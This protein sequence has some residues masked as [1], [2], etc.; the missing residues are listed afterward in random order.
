MTGKL[1][2]LVA[3]DDLTSRVLLGEI[4]M[5]VA[6]PHIVE[7]GADA[8][9]AVQAAL[10]SGEPFSLICLDIMMPQV[11]GQEVL[12]RIRELEDKAGVAPQ[13]RA[14]IIM[15][16]ALGDKANLA[17]AREL[18]C[19]AYLVKPI[20]KAKFLGQVHSLLLGF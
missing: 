20:D 2:A 13:D 7:N 11:D 12:K 5:P 10:K 17:Q 4:L 8:L 9:V 14:K 16:T 1:R 6:E 15:T 18:E 19:D 3:D